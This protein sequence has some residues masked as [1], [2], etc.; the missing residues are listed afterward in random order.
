[1]RAWQTLLATG[2]EHRSFS[3]D[4]MLEMHAL[5]FCLDPAAEEKVEAFRTAL[6]PATRNKFSTPERR[7]RPCLA[8]GSGAATHR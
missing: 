3:R 2:R 5:M 4:E 7:W 8:T 6:P 1:M